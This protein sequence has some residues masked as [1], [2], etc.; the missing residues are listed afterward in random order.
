MSGAP[1]ERTTV[2]IE[3]VA[4]YVHVDARYTPSIW[5][6]RR[7]SVGVDAQ[8]GER[9]VARLKRAWPDILHAYWG[10]TTFAQQHVKQWALPF[11]RW[12]QDEG[13]NRITNP[14]A[15]AWILYSHLSD[16][17]ADLMRER[18][19]ECRGTVRG[20]SILID[21]EAAVWLDSGAR[22]IAMHATRIQLLSTHWQLSVVPRD[23]DQ[24]P[25]PHELTRQLDAELAHLC[26]PRNI[27]S[28]VAAYL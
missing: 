24:Q 16:V 18:L 2:K 1:P 19:D 21:F 5:L 3:G 26:V 6:D 9:A 22:T 11:K 14:N 15:T 7:L 12:Q 8:E 27:W 25:P 17:E 13:R 20:L 4:A 23:A 10:R 28:I